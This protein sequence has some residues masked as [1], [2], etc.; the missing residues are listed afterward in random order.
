MKEIFKII[1]NNI[2]DENTIFVFPTEIAT[3]LWLEKYIE[4][5]LEKGLP[6]PC[7]VAKE[8]FLSWDKFKTASIKSTRQDRNIIPSIVRKVFA[9]NLIE[10][11]KELVKNGENPLFNEII[12]PKYAEFSQS[13]AGWITKVLPQL[14]LWQK[15]YFAKKKREEA[16]A[17]EEDYFT[18]YDE[19]SNFLDEN[20][21]Y[22]SAW[23]TPPF[24]NEGKTYFIFFPE[25]LSDFEEYR[26]LLSSSEHI[27][28]LSL[29]KLGFSA[30]SD[31]KPEASFFENSAQELHHLMLYIK[32]AHENQNIPY[33][34]MAISLTDADEFLPYLERELEKYCIPYTTRIGK[35]LGKYHSGRLFASIQDCYQSQFSFASIQNLLT[36]ESLFWKNPELNQALISFGIRNNCYCA[37]EEEGQ[38]QYPFNKAF[39][40]IKSE[41]SYLR[42]YYLK[43]QSCILG[44]CNAKSFK[45]VLAGYWKF[46]GI[47]LEEF[48]EK[49]QDNPLAEIQQ[50]TDRILG[51]ALSE[52]SVL[53]S[54][55][56]DKNFFGLQLPSYFDFFVDYI[57]EK[58]YLAKPK[59]LGVKIY[60]YRVAAAAP[61][62]VH[63]VPNATQK[64]LSVV[65]P[66]LSFLPKN[67][68]DEIEISDSDISDVYIRMYLGN[69]KNSTFFSASTFSYSGYSIIHSLLKEKKEEVNP[70]GIYDNFESEVKFWENPENQLV[71]ISENQKASF[72][73]WKKTAGAEKSSLSFNVETEKLVEDYFIKDGKITISASSMQSF[74]D[75]PRSM[76]F[77]RVLG[78]YDENEEAQLSSLDTGNI[79]HKVLELYFGSC[80][81]K[82]IVNFDS[83][84]NGSKIVSELLGKV[85]S[86]Y[87]ANFINKTILES[88]KSEIKKQLIQFLSWFT[89]KYEGYRVF[90]TECGLSD[91]LELEER[92][93]SLPMEVVVN[94][95]IDLILAREEELS[96]IDY[97]TKYAPSIS[98]CRIGKNGESPSNFQLAFYTYLLEKKYEKVQIEKAAF[99][100]IKDCSEK[101]V[102]QDRKEKKDYNREAF[103][104]TL[105]RIIEMGLGFATWI[106]NKNYVIPDF[107]FNVDCN[108]CRYKTSCRGLYTVSGKDKISG[109]ER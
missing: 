18:L 9:I 21:L 31:E 59:N 74:Y 78:I 49:N 51:R 87:D 46:K 88:Q 50:E 22:D 106:F 86:E 58:E 92:G 30:S 68:K 84:E 94:G 44:I 41:N 108:S 4:D 69:S 37:F 6:Y 14:A 10:K 7:A 13:F 3:D 24:A 27:K 98:S 35:P 25:S 39:D 45:D 12:S 109:D 34:K 83:F 47:F 17:I 100:S 64:Q 63:I 52:L 40:G 15:K 95:R 38:V 20:N 32:N 71:K 75:C 36:N 66:R 93:K 23:E 62:D 81:G 82:E 77:S 19:Y 57:S 8:R 90:A 5:V 60:P 102:Y 53:L 91:V 89:G 1:T 99:V 105:D 79:L 55:E 76:L 56:E 16:S 70:F 96:I 2:F 54:F 107:D 48:D 73:N 85:V 29:D 67:I 101:V 33:E 11:N 26:E 104:E 80:K 61:F 65:F 103:Q 42:D 97:K 28:L 43:L 72:E